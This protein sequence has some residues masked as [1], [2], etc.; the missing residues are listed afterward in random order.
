MTSISYRLVTKADVA[1]SEN[2][3]EHAVNY[4]TY[5]RGERCR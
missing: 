2:N 4:V 3:E 1:L 5:N